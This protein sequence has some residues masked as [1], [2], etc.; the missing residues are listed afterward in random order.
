[1]PFVDFCTYFEGLKNLVPAEYMESAKISINT[2]GHMAESQ[3]IVSYRRL[4][5][6]AEN[7]ARDTEDQAEAEAEDAERIAKLVKLA[8]DNPD[9]LQIKPE[10][11]E[12]VEAKIAMV[13]K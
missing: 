11:V 2:F 7:L 6:D 4:E 8:E 9:I 3:I 1:M 13:E 10:A 5:T 12:V